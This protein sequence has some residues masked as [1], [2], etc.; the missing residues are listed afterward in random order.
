ML[1][2][3]SFLCAI[4]GNQNFETS[5]GGMNGLSQKSKEILMKLWEGKITEDELLQYADGLSY[6]EHICFNRTMAIMIAI[7][8]IAMKKFKAQEGKWA[9]IILWC[10]RIARNF[11]Q[12][13]M[14]G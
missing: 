1:P 6:D 8:E 12:P 5:G 3:E 7:C 14:I 2:G 13:G 9:Q 10:A 11:L 4:Q